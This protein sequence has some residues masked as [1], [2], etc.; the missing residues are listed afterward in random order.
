[1]KSAKETFDVEYYRCHLGDLPYFRSTPEWHDFFRPVAEAIVLGL[2]P[3]KVFDAGCAVGFLV[4][5]LWDRGIETHGRDVSEFA[6][7]EIRADVRPWCEVGSIAEPIEGRYDLILC[8]EVLEHMAADEALAAIRN[9]TA[10]APRILFSSSPID[11]EEA[12]HINVRPTR[13]W[14]ER[15]AEAG[16]SPEVGFDATFLC[17]HAMLLTRSDEGRDERSLAAFAEIVRQRLKVAEARQKEVKT[18]AALQKDIA[19]AKLAEVRARTELQEQ[20]ASLQQD[21]ATTKLAEADAR[22]DLQQIVALHRGESQAQALVQRDMVALKEEMRLLAGQK[23]VAVEQARTDALRAERAI[24]Q[25]ADE[26]AQHAARASQE[27][28]QCAAEAQARL[29]AELRLRLM[30]GSKAWRVAQMLQRMSGRLPYLRK[31]LKFVWWTGTLQLL[32]KL[33]ERREY[34]KTVGV[35]QR[36]SFEET[37]AESAQQT[38]DQPVGL[39]HPVQVDD[40]VERATVRSMVQAHCAAWA[41]LPVFHDRHAQPTLTIL[42]DSIDANHLFGGVG[43]A[44]V[45]GAIA[46]RR[47]GA[48]MRLVTRHSTP[49]AAALGHIL[50]A[51]RVDWEGAT[52]LVHM[53]VGDDRPLPLGAE[54]IVLTTSWWSTRAVLGSVGAGRILYLL[55]E[56]ERMFY[57]FGDSRL[58]CAETLSEPDVRVLVNTR[59]LFDHLAGGPEPLPRLRCRGHWFEPAF[60]A[61]PRPKTLRSREGKQ[62]FFFYARPNNDRNLYWRGLEVVDAAMREGILSPS[63]WNIHFVGRELPDMEL[64]GGVRPIVSSKLPWLEYAELVSQMDLALCL[65]DTPHPSYPP[66]DL[67]ASGAVVV[68][69]AHGP[70]ESLDYWSHNI[71]AVPPR[72]STLRE[73]LRR[74]VA[75]ARDTAQRTANCA[76]DHIPRDWEAEL[77]PALERLLVK[78]V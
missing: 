6:I 55:Q 69:N 31:A 27:I 73:A 1:M 29:Q 8:I 37:G 15:F 60:P 66:I 63:E 38:A 54:D 35:T 64:P 59:I 61:F 40:V 30:E 42:T 4:E 47:M 17:P 14:L 36:I 48:R 67:A 65:M 74:G 76:S 41:P 21:V 50:R 34:I 77:R 25:A 24:R 2:R 70:K 44:M 78:M 7:S 75:L 33:R 71:I 26:A 68:T 51:H 12:T 58:R 20:I 39:Q 46:A 53:P 32:R 9:I 52:D 16:F 23:D 11:L 18:M 19:A 13:Y 28:Q 45:V 62:N 43:T 72:V 56:D 22:R 3:R 57:P 49:D 5:M 10:A